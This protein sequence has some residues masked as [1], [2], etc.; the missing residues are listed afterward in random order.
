MVGKLKNEFQLEIS[1]EL[2]LIVI[3]AFDISSQI[4]VNSDTNIVV[5]V[6]VLLPPALAKELGFEIIAFS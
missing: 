5:V 2:P 6:V 4:N 1:D 3:S